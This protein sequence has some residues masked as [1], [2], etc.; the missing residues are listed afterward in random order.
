MEHLSVKHFSPLRKSFSPSRRHCR[1]LGST[2]RATCNSFLDAAALR[3]TAAVV[4]DRGNVG[5]RS[6]L[7]AERIQ[8]ADSRLTTRAWALDPHFQILH[9]T[10]Q[11]GLASSLGSN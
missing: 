2:L 7:H 4:R 11:S 8:R 6:D 1:H 10:L 5:D 3:R 9:T